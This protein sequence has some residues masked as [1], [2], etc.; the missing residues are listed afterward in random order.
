MALDKTI[1]ILL[2]INKIW[3]YRK[4]WE[5]F[6]LTWC[7]VAGWLLW[8]GDAS[9]IVR[10]AFA[11]CG[12]LAVSAARGGGVLV[13][14]LNIL[15]RKRVWLR[16][17]LFLMILSVGGVFVGVVHQAQGMARTSGADSN[18]K[19]HGV[20]LLRYASE[21]EDTLP[22]DMRRL[23]LYRLIAPWK[24]GGRNSPDVGDTHFVW[25][26]ELS[27]LRLRDI[28]HPE[29]IVAAYTAE[30]VS[31][32]GYSVLFLDG[33]VKHV[34]TRGDL[35]ALIRPRIALLSTAKEAGHSR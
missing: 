32:F 19:E 20:A 8:E 13:V 4:G 1:R 27:G 30:P 7:A 14:L 26:A 5:L 24:S 10:F 28:K 3:A 34:R 33:H 17:L 22:R 31:S 16:L 2:T 9:V 11:L 18:L 15:T 25:C 6:F 12:T 35:L 29:K 21:H 23:S